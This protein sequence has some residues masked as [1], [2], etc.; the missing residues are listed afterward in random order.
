MGAP[1]SAAK[2]CDEQRSAEKTSDTD[3]IGVSRTK[4]VE[5]AAKRRAGNHGRGKDR[6]TER[7]RLRQFLGRHEKGQQ[8]LVCRRVETARRSEED[9][10]RVIGPGRTGMR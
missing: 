3:A 6:R 7:D 8:R 1:A 2:T 9:K 10:D 4:G 5:K